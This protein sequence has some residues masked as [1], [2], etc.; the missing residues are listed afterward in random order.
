[1]NTS[2][3]EAKRLAAS[4][5]LVVGAGGLGCPAL[6]A[7]SRAGVGRLVL[8]DDDTVE[9][10]N[11]HRQVLFSEQDVGESKLDAAVGALR[12]AG[13]AGRLEVV[14]SRFLPDNAQAL[15]ASVDVVVEGAD[16]FATKFLVADA[17]RLERRPVVH[18]SAVRFRATVWA[19]GP[20]GRPC[21][22]C[23][24]EDVPFGEAQANCAEAGILG[25]VAGIAGALMADLALRIAT[26]RAGVAGRVHTYD[27]LTDRLRA[28]EVGPR[29]DCPLCGPSRS[30]F[31]IDET[32]Y[33]GAIC[34]A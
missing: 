32:R 7:L 15:A 33:T 25:P 13:Y 27:G 29:G 8:A 6:L 12:R 23:L 14:R 10:S 3:D 24:F 18:G 26:G 28:V 22:R 9:L 2:A 17:C 34:A 30:I 1:M 21:Y 11:L 19:V 31:G 5:V 20:E 16:N 4:S